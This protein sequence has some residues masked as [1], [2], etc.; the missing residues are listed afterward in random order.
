MLS[1]TIRHKAKQQ[2]I[3]LED[4][5]KEMEMTRESFHRRLRNTEKFQLKELK[6]LRRVLDLSLEE[7]FE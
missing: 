2:G 7:I 5:A 4:I 1:E 6:I 3:R